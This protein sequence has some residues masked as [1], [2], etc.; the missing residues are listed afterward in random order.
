VIPSPAFREPQCPR[1]A[2]WSTVPTPSPVAC[3]PRSLIPSLTSCCFKDSCAFSWLAQPTMMQVLL[4]AV[5]RAAASMKTSMRS[6]SLLWKGYSAVRWIEKNIFTEISFKPTRWRADCLFFAN[7]ARKAS[8]K[9]PRSALD[10][11][12]R[13]SGMLVFSCVAE[14]VFLLKCTDLPK[15]NSK[16]TESQIGQTST[17]WFS[18]EETELCT[19]NLNNSFHC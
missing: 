19:E 13:S 9:R 11:L 8:E 17:F 4:L 5:R 1:P 16:F 6:C 2:L 7:E 3:C 18:R 10:Y 14:K 15:F 12:F